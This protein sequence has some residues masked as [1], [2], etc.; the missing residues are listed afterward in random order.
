MKRKRRAV[1]VGFPYYA[2]FLAE[3]M[4]EHSQ[5]WEMRAFKEQRW[6]TL[7]ALF[8]LRQADALICFGGPAPDAALAEAAR[9]AGAQVLV[10]WAG[11]DVIQAQQNPQDLQIIK[12]ER[13]NHISDG[14]WLVDELALLGL[15]AEYEP[16]TAVSPGSAVK[17]FPARFSVLT[18]LPEPRR[19]FYGERLVYEVARRMPDV[20]FTVVGT[21]GRS[22]A[23]PGNVTF[24]GYVDNMPDVIDSSCVLLRLPRHDGK[25]MLVLETLSRA[26]H[27]VWNYE[28]PH[29]RTA[30]TVDE[31]FV[32]LQDLRRR[33]SAGELTLNESGRD[34]VL[35]NFGRKETAARL[36]ARLDRLVQSNSEPVAPRRL[37]VSGLHIFCADI[38]GYARTL[39]PE[40]DV[41]L[42]RTNSR[43]EILTAILSLAGCDVWYSIGNPVADRWLTFAARLLRKPRVVHW[44]GSDILALAENS[45]LRLRLNSRNILHLAEAT[46]TVE[47]LQSYGLAPR[48]APLPPRHHHG[49][50]IPLPEQFTVLLYVPRTRSEFYGRSAFERLMERLKGEPVRYVIVGGGS[51]NV[52][53]GVDALDLGWRNDLRDAYKESSVLVRFTPHDGL[54]LMVLE[55]LSY[56]RHVIWTQPFPF[57]RQVNEYAGVEREILALYDL[58]RRGELLPQTNGSDYVRKHCSPEASLRTLAKAWDDAAQSVHAPRLAAELP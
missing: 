21:G 32:Q 56:G 4:N 58:H 23:A 46:W 38:A 30:R 13:F 12:E 24:L 18:Y 9:R 26:R 35:S 16:L 40:W 42:L 48:L 43:L 15:T 45:A 55:A 25:S 27:V 54:S 6:E 5:H 53:E 28:F 33:H 11:S 51:L 52:P 1:V 57:I 31:A 34:F 7:R 37:A 17:P 50:S 10:V 49:E 3:L 22:G 41:R 14:P 20:T 47:E 36:E 8:A 39:V 44:V 2:H 19:D 29:V